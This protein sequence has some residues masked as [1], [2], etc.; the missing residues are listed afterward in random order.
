MI[1]P[2]SFIR[3]TPYEYDV[4]KDDAG[5]KIHDARYRIQDKRKVKIPSTLAKR[6]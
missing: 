3:V 1:D 6:N 5:C 4:M 2:K